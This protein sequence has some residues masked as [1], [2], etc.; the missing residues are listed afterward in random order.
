MPQSFHPLPTPYTGIKALSLMGSEEEMLHSPPAV[1][2][3]NI[4]NCPLSVG[5]SSGSY[6]EV[7]HRTAPL[8]GILIIEDSS[9]CTS[10]TLCRG[11]VPSFMS[12][13]PYG[14]LVCVQLS[15]VSYH[16]VPSVFL[17]CLCLHNFPISKS[18]HCIHRRCSSGAHSCDFS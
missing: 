13:N 17:S 4:S 2:V 9:Y 7:P 12:G 15:P 14:Y 10:V 5:V 18:L 1:I 8:V 16:L 11:K 3:I 6:N